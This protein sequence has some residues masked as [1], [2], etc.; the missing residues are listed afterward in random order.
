VA[1]FQQAG[2]GERALNECSEKVAA[3]VAVRMRV[4]VIVR[5][6]VRVIVSVHLGPVPFAVGF[7]VYTEFGWRSCETMCF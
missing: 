7:V 2:A 4:S 5:V 6:L 1:E 3:R